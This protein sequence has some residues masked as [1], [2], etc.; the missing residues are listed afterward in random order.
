MKE[1][2]FKSMWNEN[3]KPDKIKRNPLIQGYET[4]GWNKVYIENFMM[5]CC[6]HL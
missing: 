3:I 5:V 1:N 6:E 2:F 4:A